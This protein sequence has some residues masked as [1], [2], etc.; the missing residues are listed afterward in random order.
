MKYLLTGE[1]SEP[2]LHSWIEHRARSATRKPTMS[3]Y[4]TALK[5]AQKA[6]NAMPSAS[7]Y[8]KLEDAMLVYQQAHFYANNEA[9]DLVA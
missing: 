3:R 5:A 6:F 9:H 4:L 1:R 7:N 2:T 8:R